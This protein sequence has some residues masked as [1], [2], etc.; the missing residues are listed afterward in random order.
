M[1]HLSDSWANGHE[2]PCLETLSIGSKARHEE[3]IP[4]FRMFLILCI[5]GAVWVACSAAFVLALAAAATK[6]AY[7][8]QRDVIVLEEA[9]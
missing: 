1:F 2:P 6:R 8:A 7:N 5:I 3:C 9:A 4:A